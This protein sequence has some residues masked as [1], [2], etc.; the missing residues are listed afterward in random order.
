MAASYLDSVVLMHHTT[1][2]PLS[3]LLTVSHRVPKLSSRVPKLSSCSL[4]HSEFPSCHPAYHVILSE[5]KDL[6]LPSCHS[7]PNRLYF[8]H[9]TKAVCNCQA[10]EEGASRGSQCT[11][12]FLHQLYPP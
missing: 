4:C 6:T 1:R 5:A 7:S 3:S 12:R 8:N 10:K 11:Q 9:C 2:L